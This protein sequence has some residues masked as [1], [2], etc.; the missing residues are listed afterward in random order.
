MLYFAQ[1]CSSRYPRQTHTPLS[2]HNSQ[3][4]GVLHNHSTNSRVKCRARRTKGNIIDTF[5]GL[6]LSNH[7]MSS[8]RPCQP[9]W[10]FL[11]FSRDSRRAKTLQHLSRQW[12][13]LMV[14]RV[15]LDETL[16]PLLNCTSTDYKAL[17]RTVLSCIAPHRTAPYQTALHRTAV[18][19]IAQHCAA[20]HRSA[21]HCTV[22]RCTASRS[23][24]LQHTAAHLTAPHC[25]V[26]YC[27]ASRSTALRRT[28][29]HRTVLLTAAPH[30]SALHSAA[31]RSTDYCG[32]PCTAPPMLHCTS[33]PLPAS[34]PRSSTV[35][36]QL[37]HG[38]RG[39]F[40]QPQHKLPTSVCWW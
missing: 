9:R 10:L 30:C 37:G 22:P 3:F 27:I 5:D 33:P 11:L 26:L 25:T 28:S 39:G 32:V 36:S 24:A 15:L 6:G 23:T 8:W 40:I 35:P 4:S 12:W 7:R 38:S 31:Q 13:E 20:A 21:A 18:H 34:P 2:Y 17:H 29:Q 14:W 1:L 16:R 19:C